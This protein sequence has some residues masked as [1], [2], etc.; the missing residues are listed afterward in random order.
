MCAV[1]SVPVAGSEL[2]VERRGEGEPL[3]LIQGLGA[4]TAH[5]GEPFLEALGA[6]FELIALD[7]RGIGRSGPC[8]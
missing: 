4:S 3:L 6:G 8:E 5:W 1:P 2:H 7:N